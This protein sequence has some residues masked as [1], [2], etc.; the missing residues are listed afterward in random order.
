MLRKKV[1]AA[2][3]IASVLILPAPV[4][5]QGN[6]NDDQR[7]GVLNF[8]EKTVDDTVD[9]TSDTTT[10]VVRE[11]RETI[12][13]KVTSQKE[14]VEER[15]AEIRQEMSERA[16]K[17]KEK[18]EG[19]RLAQCQNRQE[20]INKLMMKS[21]D[22]GKAKLARIQSFE[23]AIKT[24]YAEK[25]LVAE[26]YDEAVAAADAKEAGAIAAL[27]VMAGQTYQCSSVDGAN[28]SGEIRAVHDGK[29]EALKQ[30]RD[31]VQTLLLTVKS[32]F[33]VKEE[34]A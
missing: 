17:K 23:E 14:R 34:A 8:L 19:R 25:N 27:E 33:E 4:F 31:S 10:R 30:Y 2:T 15:K 3:V 9:A 6:A 21:V 26:G 24:F 28:P 11:T 18:L 16:E 12:S 22:T 20:A 13:E 32:S 5:A 29:R 7:R 1:L